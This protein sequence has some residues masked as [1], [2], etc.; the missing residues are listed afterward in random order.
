[1]SRL[2]LLAAL[3][4]AALA[5]AV[6]ALAFRTG[7]GHSADLSLFAHL[8]PLREGRL[9]VPFE[10]VAALCDP[11]PYALLALPVLAGGHV[12]YG[13]IGVAVVAGVIVVPNLVTQWLKDTTTEDRVGPFRPDIVHVDPSSWPSG[14]AT[15]ALALVLAALIVAPAGLRGLVAAAGLGFAAVVGVAVVG[16]GWH[17][18]SDVAG[19]YLIAACAACAGVSLLETR[20]APLAR[21]LPAR[22]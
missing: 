5:A 8:S 15:A 21:W 16:L 2:A 7:T 19:G 10:A 17:F 3:A 6:W 12:R 4:C 11:V 14:H 13:R 9:G 1:M 18:P 22:G 20:A